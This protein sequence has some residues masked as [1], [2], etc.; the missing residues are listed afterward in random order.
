MVNDMKMRELLKKLNEDGIHATDRM[1]RY[2]ISLGLLPEPDYNQGKQGNYLDI[3]YYIIKR[4]DNLQKNGYSLE[5]VK[6]ILKRELDQVLIEQD[7][8]EPDWLIDSFAKDNIIYLCKNIDKKIRFFKKKEIQNNEEICDSEIFNF[9]IENKLLKDKEYYDSTEV[10]LLKSLNAFID[11]KN[12]MRSDN[13]KSTIDKYKSD[14]Y[15]LNKI[16]SSAAEITVK[17]YDSW[18]YTALFQIFLFLYAREL[19]LNS[20]NLGNSSWQ[21]NDLYIEPFENIDEYNKDPSIAPE[22]GIEYWWDY[23]NLLKKDKQKI[24]I[25]DIFPNFNKDDNIL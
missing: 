22:P 4:I 8:K 9:A 21:W 7:L 5:E 1:V 6:I 14:I 17:Y 23:L 20:T 25:K 11:Q 3:H 18:A 15:D 13:G 2:Y 24:S 12:R 16:A 19:T 10:L